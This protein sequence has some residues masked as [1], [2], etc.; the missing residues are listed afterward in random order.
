MKYSKWSLFVITV[1]S[2]FFFVTHSI[3]L[4]AS[5][6]VN[7]AKENRVGFGGWVNSGVTFNPSQTNGFNGPVAF[8][9][10]ANRFQLNQL[11][12]FLQ[13]SVISET[14]KWD[15]GGRFDF[16][17][18]TDAVFTQAF[19]VPTFDVNSGEP[20]NRNNWDLHIC[21]SSTR[22]YGVALPQASL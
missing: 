18:G 6:L 17:F 14:N 22:T 4:H 11:N 12:L 2:I 3:T 5:N 15:F 9:D 10:Q 21:C 1:S 16:L 20:L 7:F 19:G 13:R 8:A